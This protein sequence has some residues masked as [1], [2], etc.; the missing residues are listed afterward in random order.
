MIE[1]IID[2]KKIILIPRNI[3]LAGLRRLLEEDL[4][5]EKYSLDPFKKFIGLEVDEVS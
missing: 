1:F 2:K 4:E 5:F 3:T